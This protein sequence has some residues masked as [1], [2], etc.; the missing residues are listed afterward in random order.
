MHALSVADE[1]PALIPDASVP[2]PACLRYAAH[3]RVR[4]GLP[5][6]WVGVTWPDSLDVS[7]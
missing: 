5:H 4:L 1:G 2:V 7:V 6:P 3:P